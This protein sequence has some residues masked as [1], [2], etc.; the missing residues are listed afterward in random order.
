MK[1]S[2]LTRRVYNLRVR[3]FSQTVGHVFCS[4]NIKKASIVDRNALKKTQV[5]DISSLV[6]KK[7]SKTVSSSNNIKQSTNINKI[8]QSEK[9]VLCTTLIIE[10]ETRKKELFMK[11][12]KNYVS[13]IYVR[14]SNILH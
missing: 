9:I 8:K 4:K 13:Y 3:D 6:L 2:Y 11:C 12:K 10:N 14:F 5:M 1:K 7:C